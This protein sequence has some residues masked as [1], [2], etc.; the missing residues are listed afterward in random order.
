MLVEDEPSDIVFMRKAFDRGRHNFEVVDVGSGPALLEH[1]GQAETEQAAPDL[2]LLDLN[3]PGMS[4]L[5][6]IS[7]LRSG[8]L[9]PHLVVIV[10]VSYTHLT[11]PTILLV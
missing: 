2:V 3:L 1:L 8:D 9:Y 4:G 5:D 7:E 6:V 11:L 10:P